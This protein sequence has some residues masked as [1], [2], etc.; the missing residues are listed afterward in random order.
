MTQQQ[1]ERSRAEPEK[2]EKW[3]KEF[4]L[5]FSKQHTGHGFLIGQ[6]GGYASPV[7]RYM[8]Q[9]FC[10]AKMSQP[11]VILPKTIMCNDEKW[12]EPS[13]MIDALQSAGINYTESE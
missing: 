12:I 2:I 4:E 1:L 13:E 7:V 10:M 6:F 9:G 3:R 11:A 5:L 8:W